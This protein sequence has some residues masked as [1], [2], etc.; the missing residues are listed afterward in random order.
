[1]FRMNEGSD[2]QKSQDNSQQITKKSASN[3]ALAFIL[4]PENK[5]KAMQVLY[6]FC[7]EVDD[8]ADDESK[9]VSVRKKSLNDW[10]LDLQRAYSTDEKPHFLV[11]QELQR[12]LSD[13]DL[14]KDDFIALL[15]GVESDLTQ[16]RIATR[17]ELET[18]CYRVASAVGLL[19]IPIFGFKSAKTKEYA[20]LLGKALQITNILRDVKSDA[21]LGRIYLPAEDLEKFGVTE[22]QILN[23]HFDKN[24]NSLCSHY[25]H[26][27]IDYYK[28][29]FDVL[30][31]EDRKAMVAAELMGAVYWNILKKLAQRKF[32]LWN[33][34]GRT[35]LSKS[36]KLFLIL[37]T[38]FQ[39]NF[40]PKSTN[41]GFSPWSQHF[42][43]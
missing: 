31:S 33:G 19:S 38:W 35:R 13:F 8:V 10:K 22:E 40:L 39:L 5:R 26:I 41:Y 24:L 30:P 15:D 42:K 4:L 43:K 16:S 20:V 28:R 36:Q 34:S 23:G 25:A 18:Y 6:A 1:M 7:R 9:P 12:V 29:A 32:N 14:K 17:E 11:N 21:E 3:L 2:I 37:K 27:A